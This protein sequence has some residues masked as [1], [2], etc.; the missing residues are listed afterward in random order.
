MRALHLHFYPVAAKFAPRL[1]GEIMN[2]S[3]PD[4]RAALSADHFEP[5]KPAPQVSCSPRNRR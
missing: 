3:R 2:L 4:L 1:A 5:P